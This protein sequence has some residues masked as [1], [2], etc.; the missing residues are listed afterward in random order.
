M[1]CVVVPIYKRFDQLTSNELTSLVKLYSILGKHSIFLIRPK[2]LE[3]Q[4]YLSHAK[5]FNTEVFVMNFPESYF[6]NVQGYNSL[7]LHKRFYR[8]FKE[9]EYILIYQTDAYVFKDDLE[10]WCSLNYDY[11]GA[12]WF[13]GWHGAKD[14]AKFLGVGK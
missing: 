13:E 6:L 14:E 8:S 9:F 2:N 11:V 12:P 10:Y 7:L 5:L 4:E 3:W 1:H